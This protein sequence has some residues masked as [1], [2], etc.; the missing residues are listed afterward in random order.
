MLSSNTIKMS[1]AGA[2]KTWG[3]CNAALSI[4]SN[5]TQTRK[6]LI[7]TYTNKG[8]DA[9]HNEIKKQNNGVLHERIIVK[10]WYQ[11]LLS[12]L[13][14]PYQ[15]Y[16]TGI[17]EVRSFD[18][19]K[20]YGYVNYGAKGNKSRYIDE[21]GFILSNYASELVIQL[22]QRSNGLVVDRMEHIYSHVFVD[23]I[24]DL[25]GD[26]LSIIELLFRSNISTI[27]VGDNK[28]ATYKTHNTRKN[29]KQSGAKIWDFFVTYQGEGLV[30]IRKNLTS[31]RFNEDICN[32]AN[33]LFSNENNMSTRM[34]EKTGHDG[35][36]LIEAKDAKDYIEHFSPAVLKYDIK[37]KTDSEFSYNFGQCKGCTF[38]RV[39]IYPN[40]PL[41]K[42]LLNNEQLK[43][44]YKYYVAVTRARYSMV[45][46]VNKF[47]SELD[48]Y[49]LVDIILGKRKIKAM[50]YITDSLTEML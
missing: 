41:T 31:R 49:V 3:I 11:F 24:Q 6:V 14:R 12:E 13:I 46:V 19:S 9:I 23:E 44:P 28:Q 29:K 26:D 17:N 1:A 40:G 15:T 36:F 7:T 8:V 27:C 16:I 34:N 5:P 42:Y 25:T 43:T 45:F 10:S 33:A 4:V 48:N 50:K 30:N 47:P 37:T 38:E 21:N 20:T 22:N 2:G 39:I 35:V 18:F 32:F